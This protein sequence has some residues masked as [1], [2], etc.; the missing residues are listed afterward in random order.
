MRTCGN[1]ESLHRFPLVVCI[2]CTIPCRIRHNILCKIALLQ[3]LV[4]WSSSGGLR[5]YIV[6]QTYI[7]DSACIHKGCV[8]K[9]HWK[10]ILAKIKQ[11]PVGVA[12]PPYFHWKFFFLRKRE[13]VLLRNTTRNGLFMVD[14][15]VSM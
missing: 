10:H 8:Y 13:S 11:K 12:P 6:S 1:S 15:T 5:V 14:P 3:E 7:W 2:A 4:A 9:L